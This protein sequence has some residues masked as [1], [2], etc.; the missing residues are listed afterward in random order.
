MYV[1]MCVRLFVCVYVCMNMCVYVY[2]YM[3][4]CMHV[5]V[6]DGG[7]ERGRSQGSLV[8]ST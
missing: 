1:C 7:K 2:V 8:A 6:C 4:M 3:S 5:C